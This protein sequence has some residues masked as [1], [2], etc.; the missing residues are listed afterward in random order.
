M[1]TEGKAHGQEET[2]AALQQ[3]RRQ[4]SEERDAA[5]QTRHGGERPRRQGR[6]GEEPEAS[7]CHRTLEG[8][9]EGQAGSPQETLTRTAP[10]DGATDGQRGHDDEIDDDKMDAVIRETPL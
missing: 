5:V 4:R 8:E 1:T 2:Q 10:K 3:E 7:H 9:K 6:Q